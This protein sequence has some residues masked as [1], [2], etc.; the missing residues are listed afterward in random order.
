MRMFPN[1]MFWLRVAFVALV[2]SVSVHNA[3]SAHEVQPGVMDIAMSDDTL[4]LFLDWTIEV[5]VAD[6]DLQGV[7]DTNDAGNGAAYD[8]ARALDPD[9]LSAAFRDVWPTV[10]EK[11]TVEVGGAPLALAISDI[12]VPEV[13][14]TELARVSTVTF[15]G[16]LPASDAPLVLGWDASYGP[17]VVRQTNVDGGYSAFLNN[18]ALSAPI[19]R[20]GGTNETASGAFL[21]YIGVGFDHIIP[22]GLDHILFVLGLFFL[23]LRMG[24]LLWQVTAF[25]LAHTVTLALGSLDIVFGE[26][27]R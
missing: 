5:A 20:E 8:E 7:A 11:I 24:A 26:V 25:T 13:G 18:G 9:A 2:S 3:A 17:L 4:T 15:T 12:S 27:D 14:D 6:L 22:L 10:S 1:L 21:S 23:A 19:P 16:T